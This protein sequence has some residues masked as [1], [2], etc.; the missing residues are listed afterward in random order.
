M[1]T[2]INIEIYKNNN[3]WGYINVDWGL[4]KN[5]LQNHVETH[6]TATLLVSKQH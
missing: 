2:G 1:I 5:K 4:N 6:S 3:E